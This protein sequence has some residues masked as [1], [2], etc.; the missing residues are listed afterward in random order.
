MPRTLN[1]SGTLVIVLV[2]V[3]SQINKPKQV[4]NK[5]SVYRDQSPVENAKD[6]LNSKP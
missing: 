2:P 5:W 1:M 4:N 3:F 6:L